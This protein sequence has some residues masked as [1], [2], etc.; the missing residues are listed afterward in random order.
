MQA[1]FLRDYRDG[2]QHHCDPEWRT[3]NRKSTKY[4]NFL[5]A[6]TKWGWSSELVRCF[7][8]K[9]IFIFLNVNGRSQWGRSFMLISL[10]F[11]GTLVHDSVW[12]FPCVQVLLNYLKSNVANG[13]AYESSNTTWLQPSTLRRTWNS[14]EVFFFSARQNLDCVWPFRQ[15]REQISSTQ[16][17]CARSRPSA[18]GC[19]N[20]QWIHAAVRKCTRDP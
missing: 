10:L 20:N 16:H 6:G 8:F 19:L 9:A 4:I 11:M 18:Q 17:C 2:I 5:H 1:P 13:A 15:T 7:V 14:T 3:I 12:N